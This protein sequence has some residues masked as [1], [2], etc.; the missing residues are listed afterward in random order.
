[1]LQNSKDSKIIVVDGKSWIVGERKIS[2]WSKSK[3]N[4]TE[5]IESKVIE[6]KDIESK[7]DKTDN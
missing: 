2:M 3:C 5:V 6:S 1:M 4:K 7:D